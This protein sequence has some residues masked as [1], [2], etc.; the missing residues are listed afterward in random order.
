MAIA[1]TQVTGTPFAKLVELGDTLVGALGSD[2]GKSR[3]QARNF[4]TKLPA[5]KN[6]GSPRFEEIL[7][8]VVMPG[9]TAKK[10]DPDTGYED[11]EPGAHVRYSVSGFK[12]G[13][14]IDG[15]KNLPARAGFGA[16]VACS[17]DVYEITLIGWSAETKAA[18]AATKAGFTVVDGRIVLKTQEE[19][20]K[21][22]L[23]QS[24]AGGNTNPGRDIAITVRRPN[25]D[26]KAWEQK[27][28]ELYLTKPWE[29]S[30][31]E[32]TS[33]NGEPEIPDEPF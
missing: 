4:E 14:V 16:G 30:N 10:G 9:T 8:L 29:A 20:D 23:H 28:D 27:A 7:H 5:T 32:T 12:W 33:S 24:R 22:V 3:R 21:Y 2:P 1:T 13:Q 25:D 11:F 15:R 19:K 17:G 31:A 26:E 18:D 6:D